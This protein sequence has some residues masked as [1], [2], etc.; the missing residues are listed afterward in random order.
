[1]V[2]EAIIPEKRLND[3]ATSFL[4]AAY[5]WLKTLDSAA[6][7]EEA[8]SIATEETGPNPDEITVQY[9]REQQT[10]RN[11]FAVMDGQANEPNAEA[12]LWLE[13]AALQGGFYTAKGA[14][15]KGSDVQRKINQDVLDSGIDSN[16][17]NVVIDYALSQKIPDPENLDPDT[18]SKTLYQVADAFAC[19]ALKSGLDEPARTLIPEIYPHMQNS[20]IQKF[21][22]MRMF[23]LAHLIKP[24]S[25]SA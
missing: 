11:F 6:T 13:T 8:K 3:L 19:A 5:D 23:H 12:T 7:L 14:E 9:Y 25:N 17:Y 21:T 18:N 20:I 15:P 22:D 10:V 24:P 2:V 4:S 16:L 1:M